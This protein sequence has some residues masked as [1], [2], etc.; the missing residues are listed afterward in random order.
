MGAGDQNIERVLGEMADNGMRGQVWSREE[1]MEKYK[2]EL[3]R[4]PG[5]AGGAADD[6]GMVR[7]EL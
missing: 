5:E 1:L 2:H 3:G 7:E 4:D 6:A